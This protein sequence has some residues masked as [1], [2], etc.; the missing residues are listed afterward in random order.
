MGAAISD[1]LEDGQVIST[2]RVYNASVEAD[3]LQGL[4]EQGLAAAAGAP[5]SR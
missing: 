2:D 5:P 3:V 1:G 4:R